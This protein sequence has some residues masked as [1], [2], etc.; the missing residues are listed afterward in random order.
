MEAAAAFNLDILESQLFKLTVGDGQQVGSHD[1]VTVFYV[2]R[3]LLT[4]LSPEFRNHIE[5]EMKEGVSGEMVLHDVDKETVRRFLQWAY[6]KEYT[7]DSGSQPTSSTVLLHCK[8]YVFADRFNVGSLKDLSFGKLTLFLIEQSNP[9]P[10]LSAYVLK[11]L[12]YAIDNLPAL[13]ES[14]VE[15]L[16]GYIAWTLDDVLELPGFTE[17]IQAHPDAA[18]ALFRLTGR[19]EQPPWNKSSGVKHPVPIIPPCPECDPIEY[20]DHQIFLQEL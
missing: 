17:M 1:S 12:R 11:A 9:D 8:L 13:S 2:Q 16:L 14:L 5:N 4:S 18:V 10:S 3:G 15:F 7:T 19:T 20:F 6:T